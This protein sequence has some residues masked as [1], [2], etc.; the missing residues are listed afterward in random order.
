MGEV[1]GL[2]EPN[3][4]GKTT[5]LRMLALFMNLI[6]SSQYSFFLW[7]VLSFISISAATSSSIISSFVGQGLMI[8]LCNIQLTRLLTKAGESEMKV[9]VSS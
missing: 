3:A 1:Y 4:A 2:I 8:I 7:S 5:L 6:Y 9:L